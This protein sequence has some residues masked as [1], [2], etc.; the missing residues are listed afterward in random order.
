MNGMIRGLKGLIAL[1]ALAALGLGL[2][3]V[4]A[5]LAGSAST[6]DLIS[7]ASLTIAA[8]AWVA[9]AWLLL[10]V[11]ATVLEQLPGA[12]GHA[13]SA[14][15]GRITSQSSRTLLRSVLGVAA[16]TPLTIGVAH[17]TPGEAS[18]LRPWTAVEPASTVRLGQATAADWRTTEKPSTIRLTNPRTTPAPT[19][20]AVPTSQ[21]QQTKPSSRQDPPTKR[22]G[23][24]TDQRTEAE[25]EELERL[26]AEAEW[27]AGAD[28]RRAGAD[29]ERPGIALGL[30]QGRQAVGAGGR[31]GRQGVGA[32]GRQQPG[33]PLGQGFGAEGRQ[34]PREVQPTGRVGVPD[35]P[36]VGAPTRYTDVRTGKPVR[37]AQVVKPGDSLWALAEAELGPNATD[38][39]IAARWPQWYAANRPTVGADPNLIHPG[40][41]LRAPR[42]SSP[43][44][45]TLRVPVTPST[46]NQHHL[47]PGT[48]SH[49]DQTRPAPGTS[50]H[51]DGSLPAPGAPS[52]T[53]Q[54]HRTP[55]SPSSTDQGPAA[56]SPAGQVL[57]QSV[58]T[59]HQ[60]K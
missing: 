52:T 24:G 60:E 48:S 35:R 46:T 20:P 42:T 6:H 7:M 49:T 18:P 33:I 38:A 25:L 8:V 50:S 58:P 14:V 21:L 26:R 45:Q 29:V 39:E 3:W 2:R 41:T 17:A 30:G 15:A 32:E 57:D 47:V 56:P 53:R 44:E 43:T 5:D 19:R 11:L 55:T 28:A 31:Q 13:A 54:T 59:T 34:R 36:T 40:Q 22:P 16:V 4:S 9:Y 1:G 12:V 51:T 27:R 23:A 10:A 37:P